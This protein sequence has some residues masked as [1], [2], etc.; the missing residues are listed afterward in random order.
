[1]SQPRRADRGPG[2]AGFTLIELVLVVT[3]ILVMTSII[4]PTFRMTPS[5]QVEN[6][7]EL[8]VA[9]LELA[10]TEALGTRRMLRI[11]FDVVG[12]TYTAYMDD[13]NDGVID[14]DAPE[15]SAFPEF[16]VRELDNLVIFGR[17]SATAIPG[18]A[19]SGE[20]TFANDRFTL[21]N[22]GIPAPWGSMGTIYITHS[23]DNTAV[24]AVSVASSGSFTAW[25]W[26][27][28]AGEWR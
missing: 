24:A 22:Q 18:D 3:I 19:G 27:P 2:T 15:I 1:M 23:R 16:G 14:A 12:G 10:R 4:G 6:Q 20:V 7:A 17:G 26:W 25:R 11:D 28:D 9:H 21:D 8:L 13:D 5:R